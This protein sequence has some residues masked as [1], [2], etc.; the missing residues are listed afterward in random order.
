[1]KNAWLKRERK[2]D[3][4]KIVRDAIQKH[5]A[6]VTVTGVVYNVGVDNG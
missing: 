1:M 2:K 4:K 5:K 6:K 3:I